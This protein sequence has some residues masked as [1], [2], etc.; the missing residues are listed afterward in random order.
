MPIIT[1]LDNLI[2]SAVTNWGTSNV[3]VMVRTTYDTNENGIVDDSE[4]LSG[5]SPTYYL[6]RANHTGTIQ[7][8]VISDYDLTL[9]GTG[10]L[11][12]FIPSSDYHPATKKYVDDS[13]SFAGGGDMLKTVYDTNDNGVVD[14][15]QALS[16]Q[17][18]SYY[19]DWTN[20]TGTPTTVSGYG[21]TDVYTTNQLNNGQLDSRYYTETEVDALFAVQEW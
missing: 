5:N 10:N 9:A 7:H 17:G 6:D 16:G 14:N 19:L 12:P 11:T 15:S 4:L 13:I 3:N 2:N 20:F 8:T 21:I 18:A 1:N